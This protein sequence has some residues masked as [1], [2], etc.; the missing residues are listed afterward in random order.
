MQKAH[1]HK[2]RFVVFPNNVIAHYVFNGDGR[3]NVDPVSGKHFS[4][5][6]MISWQTFTT[7]LSMGV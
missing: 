5:V 1:R 4:L 7:D 6:R 3:L 2:D